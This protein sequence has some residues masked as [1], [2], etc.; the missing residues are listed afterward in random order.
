L[1]VAA[2]RFLLHKLGRAQASC[3]RG[4]VLSV[5]PIGRA[6]AHPFDHCEWHARTHTLHGGGWWGT[7][8][9]SRRKSRSRRVQA[10][11]KPGY[12][13]QQ[14]R[15]LG[16]GCERGCDLWAANDQVPPSKV[17]TPSPQPPAPPGA[18]CGRPP[19]M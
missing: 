18:R 1:G 2:M 19:Y 9:R 5:R 16:R 12:I 11:V 8:A 13:Q 3:V 6:H 14:L 17:K 4:C 15:Q 10:G 7:W